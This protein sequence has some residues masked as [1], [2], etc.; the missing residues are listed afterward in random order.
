MNVLVVYT[1]DDECEDVTN[2]FKNDRVNLFKEEW[3]K[4]DQQNLHK[5]EL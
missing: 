4:I 2:S 5:G 1:F 3:V